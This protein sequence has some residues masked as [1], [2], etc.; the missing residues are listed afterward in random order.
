M[1]SKIITVTGLRAERSKTPLIKGFEI[2]DI[3]QF[4]DR[5][6]FDKQRTVESISTVSPFSLQF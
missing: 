3:I 6:V 1:F 2:L 5:L 4:R